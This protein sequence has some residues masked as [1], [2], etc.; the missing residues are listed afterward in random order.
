MSTVTSLC[1]YWTYVW[2]QKD[3]LNPFLLFPMVHSAQLNTPW[4][5]SWSWGIVLYWFRTHLKMKDQKTNNSFL[6]LPFLKIMT[7]FLLGKH[8]K[9]SEC[10]LRNITFKEEA[11]AI[12]STILSKFTCNCNR[13]FKQVNLWQVRPAPLVVSPHTHLNLSF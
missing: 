10:Y 6:I 12:Q 4:L 1:P 3:R 8:K 2:L 5:A 9:K 7:T 11:Q 13:S